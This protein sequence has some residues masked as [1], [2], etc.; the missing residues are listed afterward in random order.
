M[1]KLDTKVLPHVILHSFPQPSLVF[2]QILRYPSFALLLVAISPLSD[3]HSQSSRPRRKPR[4]RSRVQSVSSPQPPL[5]PLFYPNSARRFLLSSRPFNWQ[6][7]SRR[8]GAALS[9]PTVQLLSSPLFRVL[10]TSSSVLAPRFFP[11][12]SSTSLLS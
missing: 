6:S 8:K 9:S 1:W 12:V 5:Q 10:Q 4:C 11:Q 2:H 3:D 7:I